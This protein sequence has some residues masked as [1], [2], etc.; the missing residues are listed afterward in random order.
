MGVVK[1]CEWKRHPPFKGDA[2]PECQKQHGISVI[3]V[4]VYIAIA[5]VFLLLLCS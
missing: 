5:A 4:M 2:C 3:D 1:R